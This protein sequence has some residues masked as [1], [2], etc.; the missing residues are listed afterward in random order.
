MINSKSLGG[1]SKA[2]SINILRTDIVQKI[3]LFQQHTQYSSLGKYIR[4][5]TY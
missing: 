5:L 3:N 4:L 2:V 1:F